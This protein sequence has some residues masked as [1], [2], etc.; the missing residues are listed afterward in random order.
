MSF[1][2]S[3]TAKYDLV[4]SKEQ[5]REQLLVNRG[6]K[7][8]TQIEEFFHP[9]L[10]DF[11]SVFELSGIDISKAR[12]LEAIKKG[13]QVYIYGDYD[14]DG[15]CA[16]AIVYHGLSSLGAKVLPYI[17]H[18]EKEGYGL[19]KAGLDALKE[20]GAGLVIT[21][22]NGIV[23]VNE[24]DYA[25]SLGLDLIITDHHSPSKEKPKALAI[26]H[27]TALSGSG[28]AWALIKSLLPE[29]ES[30]KLLDLVAVATVCDML[31]LLDVNRSLVSEGLKVLNRNPRIG[32]KA[33]FEEC[34]IE[35][36]ILGTYH[37][38]HIIGPRLNAMGRMED[39]TDSLRLLCTKDYVKAK[40]LARLLCDTNDQKKKLTAEAI[41]QA[42]LMIGSREELMDQKILVVHSPDWIPGIIGLVAGRLAEEYKLPAIAISSSNGKAKGSARSVKGV[43]IVDTIRE[44][45]DLLIDVGGHPQAAGFSLETIKIDQFKDKLKQIMVNLSVQSTFDTEV[46]GLVDLNKINRS[47][48]EVI[49]EFEPY[50]LSN[51]KPIFGSENVSVSDI[52]TV[53]VDKKHLK[54][55]IS[56]IDAIAFGFG[57]LAK[58][59]KV[60]DK[61]NLSYYLEINSFNGRESLQLKVLDLQKTT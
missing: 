13:E 39:A 17:P 42:R 50:G 51:P 10:K 20:K 46:E 15:V 58:T 43:N 34:S 55:N 61:V 3:S 16:T 35:A 22:D 45:S 25:K 7:T 33:L 44:V 57:D 9:K 60:G 28:V 19:S 24:A 18:R 31:P 29:P 26:V 23:A 2:L 52:K 36:G 48:L 49:E 6:L 40:K 38:G 5:L 32:F 59:L 11:D 37:I 4:T 53:G 47:W 56:G 8:Q 21:V 27:S 54:L 12:I 30:H 14:A 1:K 41:D